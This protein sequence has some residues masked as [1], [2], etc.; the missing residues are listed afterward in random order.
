MRIKVILFAITLALAG[1]AGT[2]AT[3]GDYEK[4]YRDRC[5]GSFNAP[6]WCDR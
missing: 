2:F 6:L 3:K 1:C 4:I 5:D